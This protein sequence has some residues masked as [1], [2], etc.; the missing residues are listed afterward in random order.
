[1][2]VLVINSG[3]SSIKYQLL[4]MNTEKVLAKGLV[5]RIGIEGSRIIHRKNEEKYVIEKVIKNH[6]EG[7]K[8][9]LDL[10]TSEDYKVISSLNEID[11]VGHRVVHGG[12]RFSSSVIIDKESLDAIEMMSFLAPLHN[13]A[14]VM[15]I[16]AAIELLPNVPQIAVFDTSFHQTMPKTSFLYAIPYEYYEKYKI[17]RYGFHGTSHKYVSRRAAEILGKDIKTLKIIT[18]H[19]GNGASIAAVKNGESFDTSMGFTPLE[20]LVMGTRSGDIDPAI[21]SFLAQEEG[22]TAKE[23]VEILNNKSGVYGITKGFSSDMRDIEDKALEGDK[24]CRLAL[25]IY[26]YRI[27]KYIGAYAAAMNGVDVIVFTAGVGENSPVTREE[28]CE[29]YLT[30][31]GVKIDKEKNNFKGLERIISTPDS[32]VAVLVVPTNEELMIA[33]ETKEL[34]STKN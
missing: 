7:L 23:V 14:N 1:M 17:R 31:L 29:K 8:E 20:G 12:E 25:D 11:A 16:K 19:I 18:S 34:V 21:V 6:E 27:A 5:E 13:P 26:E 3:S 32:K 4:E 30:Y 22:L 33:R 28:I 24:V 10:L 15:G 2:K 9:V